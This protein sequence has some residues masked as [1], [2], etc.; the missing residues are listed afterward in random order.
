MAANR[1]LSLFISQGVAGATAAGGVLANAKA[2]DFINN[3]SLS[4]TEFN[5]TVGW[6]LELTG[7]RT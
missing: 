6:A 1:L 2:E 7:C 5:I 4:V 3:V